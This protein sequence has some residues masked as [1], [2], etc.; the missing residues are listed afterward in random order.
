VQKG[1]DFGGSEFGGEFAGAATSST[2]V[3]LSCAP[4]CSSA[5]LHH[6]GKCPQWVESRQ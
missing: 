1:L 6:F 5:H 2:A 3:A 4:H